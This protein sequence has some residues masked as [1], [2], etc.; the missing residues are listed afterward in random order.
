MPATIVGRYKSPS[1]ALEYE[2]DANWHPNGDGLIWSASVR[3]MRP[4]G[5]SMYLSGSLRVRDGSQLHAL[6]RAVESDIERRIID[7]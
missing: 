5:S 6:I 3:D 2:Y 7:L 1:S 4:S